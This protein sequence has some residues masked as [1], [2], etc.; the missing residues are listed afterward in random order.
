MAHHEPPHLDLHCLQIQLHVSALFGASRV[1][2][3]TEA[4]KQTAATQIRGAV[5]PGREMSAVTPKTILYILEIISL[6][7]KHPVLQIFTR[8][9]HMRVCSA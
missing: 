4:L 3:G 1:Q 5:C 8:E 6:L 9:S 7:A 2:Y